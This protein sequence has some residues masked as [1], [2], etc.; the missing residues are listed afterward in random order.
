[1]KYVPKA[2]LCVVVGFILWLICSVVF[3]LIVAFAVAKI[4]LLARLLLFIEDS[5]TFGH[6]VPTFFRLIPCLLPGYVIAKICHDNTAQR[7]ISLIAVFCVITILQAY[8]VFFLDEGSLWWL[9]QGG[10]GQ[11]IGFLIFTADFS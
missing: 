1:M 4:D 7:K 10:V 11:A 2:I 6:L 9:I 3:S 8:S 5:V